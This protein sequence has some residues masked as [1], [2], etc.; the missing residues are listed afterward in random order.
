VVVSDAACLPEVAGG[1]A[2]LVPVGDV[3]GLTDALAGVL[4]DGAR[5]ERLAAAGR[6]RAAHFT[7]EASAVAHARAYAAARQRAAG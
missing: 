6:S 3:D 5:R 7:W 4:D 2:E 1:A